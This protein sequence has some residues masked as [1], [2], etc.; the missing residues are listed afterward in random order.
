MRWDQ[1]KAGGHEA[2][3]LLG[4]CEPVFTLTACGVCTILANWAT[5]RV[6]P[7]WH[8]PVNTGK[9]DSMAK[10]ALTSIHVL[11]PQST[12]QGLRWAFTFVSV[13]INWQ[14]KGCLCSTVG[15]LIL[16]REPGREEHLQRSPGVCCLSRNS[17]GS[18]HLPA[19]HRGG[20]GVLREVFGVED[21]H[22]N[23][24]CCRMQEAPDA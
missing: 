7:W 12:G 13:H 17:L 22:F 9:W 8:E 2:A 1:S 6:E 18:W 3:C 15:V 24:R 11:C 21:L 23:S 4:I 14:I 19:S 16:L 10:Q 5:V 20:T